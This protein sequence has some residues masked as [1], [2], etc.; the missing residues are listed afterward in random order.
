LLETTGR[1]AEFFD[2][3]HDGWLDI[4]LVNGS[5]FEGGWTPI[6]CCSCGIRGGILLGVSAR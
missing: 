3:D 6:L 2:F 4:F 5:R 1:G